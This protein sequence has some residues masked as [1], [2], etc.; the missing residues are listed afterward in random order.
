MAIF[1]RAIHPVVNRASMVSLSYLMDFRD[2]PVGAIGAV[3][4]NGPGVIFVILGGT[5][6]YVLQRSILDEMVNRGTVL[7]YVYHR[8]GD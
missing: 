6:S 8:R 2:M 7:L 1:V 5:R 3:P 4:N